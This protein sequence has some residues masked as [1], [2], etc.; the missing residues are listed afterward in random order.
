MSG[1]ITNEAYYSEW[2]VTLHDIDGI[3]DSHDITPSS[4]KEPA[5]RKFGV[6]L[7]LSAGV[8][9]RLSSNLNMTAGFAYSQTLTNLLSNDPAN[10][11]VVQSLDERKAKSYHA[12]LKIG[13]EYCF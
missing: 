13:L 11:L 10:S 1:R 2:N 12:H 9:C 4:G 7:D 8:F 5:Y 3:Y 6:A